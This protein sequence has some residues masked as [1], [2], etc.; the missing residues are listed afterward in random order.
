M[1]EETL[2]LALWRTRFGRGYGLSLRDDDDD[3]KH[4]T[5]CLTV[6]SVNTGFLHNILFLAY[7]ETPNFALIFNNFMYFLTP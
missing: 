6:Q 3:D 7:F 4:F 5:A 1:K 2:D